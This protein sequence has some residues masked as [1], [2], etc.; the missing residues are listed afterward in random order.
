[1]IKFLAGLILGSILGI[2]FS[3]YA[4]SIVGASSLLSGWTV[5]Y[6][7]RNLCDDPYVDVPAKEIKC[8][9]INGFYYPGGKPF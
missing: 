1:M 3:A 4:A 8:S 2:T 9:D 7:D 6:P 5:T